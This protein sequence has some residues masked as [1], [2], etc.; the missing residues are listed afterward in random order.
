MPAPAPICDQPVGVGLLRRVGAHLVEIQ[1]Q[2]EQMGLADQSTH[3][4][5]LDAFGIAPP[6]G[7]TAQTFRQWAAARSALKAARNDME[8]AAREEEWLRQTVD[9]LER[10]ALRKAKRMLS[11]Q[12]ASAFS[13]MSVAA[14]PLP[15]HSRN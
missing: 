11:R 1:G 14:K 8:A 4:D 7:K 6:A 13:A 3:L 2:H 5:L 9:D 10:L 12:H 15:P